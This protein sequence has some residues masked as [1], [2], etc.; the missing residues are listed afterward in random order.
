MRLILNL[1]EKWRF[2]Q[3]FSENLRA[4]LYLLYSSIRAFILDKIT[5]KMI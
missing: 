3:I 2:R 4:L 1:R 5:R